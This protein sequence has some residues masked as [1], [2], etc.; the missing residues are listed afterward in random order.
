M[1]V[2]AMSETFIMGKLS[3]FINEIYCMR[4][5]RFMRTCGILHITGSAFDSVLSITGST[6]DLVA[7]A[8]HQVQ[9]FIKNM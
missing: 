1:Y 3:K 6:L 7:N 2:L 8:L 9:L 4:R 5:E